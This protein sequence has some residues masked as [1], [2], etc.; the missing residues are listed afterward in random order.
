MTVKCFYNLRLHQFI[1]KQ[2]E[3]YETTLKQKLGFC[4]QVVPSYGRKQYVGYLTSTWYT[5]WRHIMEQTLTWHKT[6]DRISI[7]I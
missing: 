3:I 5:A 4:V 1:F 2:K 7:V 6:E